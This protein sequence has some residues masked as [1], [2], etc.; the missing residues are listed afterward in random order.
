MREGCNWSR[1]IAETSGANFWR[2][3]YCCITLSVSHCEGSSLGGDVGR[4]PI[5]FLSVFLSFLLSDTAIGNNWI[6]VAL[7]LPRTRLFS[8]VCKSSFAIEWGS[9]FHSPLPFPPHFVIK[10][11]D[12]NFTNWFCD[13]NKPEGSALRVCDRV[14]ICVIV[15]W[16]DDCICP[17]NNCMILCIFVKATN[18]VPIMLQSLPYTHTNILEWHISKTCEI[19]RLI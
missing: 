1:G 5:Y 2:A 12:G 17:V 8:T 3:L 7:S 11:G 18:N 15:E 4:L 10:R 6:C 14:E 16:A 13:I 9:A 19:C